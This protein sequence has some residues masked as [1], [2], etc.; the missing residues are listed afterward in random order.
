MGNR[1]RRLLGIGGWC[2]G[3]ACSQAAPV[4]PA[5]TPAEAAWAEVLRLDRS[6]QSEGAQ[7]GRTA[8]EV[9]QSH[10][11]AQDEALRRYLGTSGSEAHAFEAKLRLAQ[12]LFALGLE[13][14]GEQLKQA[15]YILDTLEA[16]ATGTQKAH[17]AF[18]RITQRMRQ[19]R[20]PDRAQRDALL[21]AARGFQ[22]RFPE[23]PRVAR[24]LVEVATQLDREPHLKKS[25]LEDANKLALEPQLK[26]RIAD[27]LKKVAL[28]GQ[29]LALI[30]PESGGGEI[31][32]EALR[33]KPVLLLFF[34]E[35][36]LPSL[37]AWDVL[38]EALKAHPE[39]QRIG[40]SLDTDA[41]S[42]ERMKK[43]HGEGWRLS[44]D[45]LGWEGPAVRRQGI[46]AAPTAWLIDAEGRLVS[47]NALDG[48]AAQL[49]ELGK[50]R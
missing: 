13:G 49:A 9:Y 15:Q 27:D 33:G 41:G 37:V 20:F 35:T 48:T 47:L 7:G 5:K 30:L 19:N 45:G 26:M 46:N 32:L 40:V 10:L 12:V 16:S 3:V 29:V 18:A 6:P 34:S 23:D 43:S 42:L 2:A 8:K 36:S 21:T 50:P 22:K 1:F 11:K 31:K 14:G 4:P 17:V 24:L 44:W 25:V 38:N 39:V 28:M